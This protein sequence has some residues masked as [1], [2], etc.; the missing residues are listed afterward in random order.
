MTVSARESGIGPPHSKML[1]LI[2]ACSSFRDVLECGSPMPPFAG[3]SQM[4][5][6]KGFMVQWSSHKSAVQFTTD[7]LVCLPQP[8]LASARRDVYQLRTLDEHLFQSG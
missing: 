7:E 8:L 1:A 6:R 2:R 5:F 4:N 3:D